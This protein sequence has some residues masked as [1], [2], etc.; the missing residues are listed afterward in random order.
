[1]LSHSVMS[2]SLRP[3][4]RSSVHEIFQARI[5]ER[6]AIS[7]CRGSSQP[8]D[9]THV[10]CICY[11]GKRVLYHCVTWECPVSC[12]ITEFIISY[13]CF[14]F[15]VNSLEGIYIQDYVICK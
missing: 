10:S 11:I 14:V 1:M 5:L 7:Y 13:R 4:G 2:D 3:H 9:Q 6:V 15:M 12:N 8:R